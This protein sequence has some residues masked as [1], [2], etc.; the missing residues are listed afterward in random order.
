[1]AD[2]KIA[3]D[4]NAPTT[5]H[6]EKKVVAETKGSDLTDTPRRESVALNIVE[7][8]LQVSFDSTHEAVPSF[9]ILRMRQLTL[10]AYHPRSSRQ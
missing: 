8:P 5:Y 3:S 9:I 2:E 7:N 6:D 4:A 1:M 10:L